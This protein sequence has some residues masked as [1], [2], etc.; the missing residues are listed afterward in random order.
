MDGEE[1]QQVAIPP[2]A[3]VHCPLVD[4]KLRSINK[5]T[6]CEHFDGLHDRFPGGSHGFV[7]RF[8]V[9]CKARPVLREMVETE[10]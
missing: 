7:V 5:C 1:Q 2:T 4:F 8:R 6:A 10:E 3:R 9:G